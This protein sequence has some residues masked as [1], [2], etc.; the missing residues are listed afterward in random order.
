CYHR[1][2]KL[3]LAVSC[4]WVSVAHADPVYTCKEASASTHINVTFKPEV[5]LY[6]LS[7]WVLGFT[8]KNIVFTP[9]VAKHAMKV[10]IIAPNPLTPKQALQLFVDAVDATGLVVTVKPDTITIKLGPGMPKTCPDVASAT[11]ATPPPSPP[12]ATT[13]DPEPELS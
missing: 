6:E 4:L 1:S 11:P 8:C 5:S 12:V 2:M 10:H 3:A 9:E 7:T 13:L